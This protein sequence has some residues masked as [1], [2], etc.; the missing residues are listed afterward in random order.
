MSKRRAG[1]E[2]RR[3]G[4]SARGRRKLVLQLAAMVMIIMAL[5]LFM[6]GVMA[7]LTDQETMVG[8][9]TITQ[10][11]IT[12]TPTPSPS[13]SPTPTLP[14][15]SFIFKVEWMGLEEDEQTPE[16]NVKLYRNVE[17]NGKQVTKTSKHI[18]N[19]DGNGYYHAWRM[20]PGDYW[21]QSEALEGFFPLYRNLEPNDLVV[22][23]LF[24]GGT[25]VYYKIP[26]TGDRRIP[27]GMLWASA[28]LC[29]AGL[30]MLLASRRMEDGSLTPAQP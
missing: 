5:G 7:Y 29:A 17:V 22:D 12:P 14:L 24:N 20:R 2:N 6:G 15:E 11:F 8:R 16:F 3:T 23:K 13:P 1:Q 10:D 25:L 9:V 26:E 27:A 21:L 18:F 19:L 30:A 4:A 28:L